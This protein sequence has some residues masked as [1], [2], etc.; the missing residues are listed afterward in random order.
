MKY[1]ATSVFLVIILFSC[2]ESNTKSPLI[3]VNLNK[4]LI[5]QITISNYCGPMDSCQI[6]TYKLTNPMI[7]DLVNRLNKS[8]SIGPCEFA[9]EYW[10]RIY[11]TD[12]TI[13]TYITNGFLFYEVKEDDHLLYTTIIE[14]EDLCLKI[15]DPDYVNNLWKELDKDRKK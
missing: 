6:I 15:K 11:F 8:D 7:E 13:S 12:S 2:G 3:K 14:A 5:S 4:D 9:N 1:I 10:L